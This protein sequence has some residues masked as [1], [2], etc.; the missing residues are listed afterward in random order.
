MYLDIPLP[1]HASVD[2]LQMRQAACETCGSLAPVL[3]VTRNTGQKS[4]QPTSAV[5]RKPSTLALP[6]LLKVFTPSTGSLVL[7]VPTCAVFCAD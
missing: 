2:M 5:S 6:G 3:S 7:V 1:G 4:N